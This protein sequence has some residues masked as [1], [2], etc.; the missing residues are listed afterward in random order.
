MNKL[1]T[2]S[3]VAISLSASCFANSHSSNKMISNTDGKKFY[4]KSG[5]TSY[6]GDVLHKNCSIYS[7]SHGDVYNNRYGD[8][9]LGVNF[10]AGHHITNHIRAE[11][12]ILYAVSPQFSITNFKD[13]I[14]KD[15]ENYGIK[16]HGFSGL[17]NTY[18]D[19]IETSPNSSLYINLGLGLSYTQGEILQRS[20]TE[21][22]NPTS[23][24]EKLHT[25]GG[26]ANFVYK[27][28]VGTNISFAENASID[29]G[30]N[31][32]MINGSP[33]NISLIHYDYKKWSDELGDDTSYGS[34][35]LT[36]GIRFYI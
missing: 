36:A 21:D 4:F 20:I 18:F 17:I 22:N 32:Y 16:I 19:L 31:Y 33:D 25:Y 2:A 14:A 24:K 23:Y 6:V 7:N 29:I 26:K 5:V 13:I 10:A 27:F 30:Y 15:K 35:S 3:I 1:I 34:H 8:I 9:S 28:G 12:E 11:A